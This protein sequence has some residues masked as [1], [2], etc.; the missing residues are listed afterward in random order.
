MIG[1]TKPGGVLSTAALQ[2]LVYLEGIRP[3]RRPV[4]LGTELVGFSSLL[5]CHHL[6]IRPVAMIESNARVTAFA[7]A[8]YFPPLLGVPLL[9]ETELVAINGDRRV[10]EVVLRHR[11]AERTL[12]TDGV[13]VTGQFVPEASVLLDSHLERDARTGGPIVDEFGRCSDPDYFAAGNLLRAVETAGWSWSEGRAA[14]RSIALALTG[15][16]PPATG[17]RRISVTGEA[18]KYVVPQRL[19]LPSD[20]NPRFSAPRHAGGPGRIGCLDGRLACLVPQS[21]GGARTTDTGAGAGHPRQGARRRDVRTL[22]RPMKTLAIDQGTT[23]T[24]ALLVDEHGSVT[25]IASHAHRQIY[26]AAG[27]G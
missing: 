24:R 18:L 11:G 6:G 9:L 8:R 21:D 1:G 25:T 17:A 20:D 15:D 4:V 22:G 13:I 14:G 5:T 7:A 2:G 27:V 3:F 23:S 26:P 19:A 16:L 12:A 10:E